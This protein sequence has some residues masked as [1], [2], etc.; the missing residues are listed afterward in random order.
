MRSVRTPFIL[1]LSN[2][3]T[4]IRGSV[5]NWQ[6]LQVAFPC[7]FHRSQR[8]WALV[9]W[10]LRVCVTRGRYVKD[11]VM[12]LDSRYL[13]ILLTQCLFVLST[14]RDILHV[15][16]VGIGSNLKVIAFVI[17]PLVYR[18]VTSSTLYHLKT[19]GIKGLHTMFYRS[20][21]ESL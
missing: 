1:L 3:V 15:F 5:Q 4:K 20:S 19:N 12:F 8:C 10:L 18:R 9:T 21:L 6:L 13:L 7:H 16:L 17:V 11:H 2:V 14:F